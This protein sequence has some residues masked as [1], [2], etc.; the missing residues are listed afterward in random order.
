MNSR[1][2]VYIVDDD[3]AMR[4]SLALLLETAGY[5][6]NVFAGTDAFLARCT[7]ECEGCII[8]DLNMPGMNGLELH[9]SLRRRNINLAAVFLTGYGTIPAAVKAMRNGATDFLTK[10]ID[11]KVLLKCVAD[12][13]DRSREM[14]AHSSDARAVD[15]RLQ[16]LTPR[17]REIVKLIAEG[18]TSKEIGLALNISYRTVDVHRRHLMHKLGT[19]SNLEVARLVFKSGNAP[20]AQRQ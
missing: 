9:D 16:Q 13:L 10:P 4:D 6:V 12:A 5:T 3:Q 11:G 20:G 14:S 1:D 19:S 7:P 17:E 2:K 18:R 15:A 8:L